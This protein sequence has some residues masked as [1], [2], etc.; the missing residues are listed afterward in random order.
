MAEDAEDKLTNNKVSPLSEAKLVWS[1]P[2]V[3]EVIKNGNM[4]VVKGGGHGDCFVRI[5]DA[6]TSVTL[7]NQVKMGGDGHFTLGCGPFTPGEHCLLVWLWN[8]KDDWWMQ[9]KLVRIDIGSLGSEPIL[10]KESLE[11]DAVL[12]VSNT[13]VSSERWGPGQTVTPVFYNWVQGNIMDQYQYFHLV[14]HPNANI[15]IINAATWKQLCP[16]SRTNSDGEAKLTLTEPLD[17][18][19]Y[20]LIAQ[21]WDWGDW[22]VPSVALRV[23]I[24]LKPR[25]TTR[26]TTLLESKI[27]GDGGVAGATITLV[28]GGETSVS[29]RAI[30][31]SDGSW[32]ANVSGLV[33][34]HNTL[35]CNQYFPDRKYLGNTFSEWSDRGDVT[36]TNPT[37]TYPLQNASINR[38]LPL[39]VTG[40]GAA[41]YSKVQISIKGGG[42]NFGNADADLYGNWQKTLDLSRSDVGDFTLAARHERL[43]DWSE[44][45]FRLFDEEVLI[46]I[47]QPRS[48][49]TIYPEVPIY[50]SHGRQ[51]YTVEVV[52]DLNYDFKIGEG[53][54]RS[55]GTWTLT[56]RANAM[57]PG[58]FSIVALLKFEGRLYGKSG[59]VAIKV[60]PPALT[61]VTVTDPN[62]PT[63]KFSGTGHTGATVVIT[64]ES[65]PGG[66]APQN[67][68][69]T[70]GTWET[71]ATNWPF[72]SYKLKVIQKVSDYA[73][74]WIESQPYT[75]AVN[76][77]LANTRDVIYTNGY[78]PTFSGKGYTG[79]TVHIFNQ[80]GNT[81]AAPEA[82]VSNSLWS[83]AAPAVWG[84]TFKRDVYI[85]QYLYGTQSPEW[86][87][88][89]VT[90]PPLAPVIEKV[91]EDGLSPKISGTCWPGAV[92]NLTYSGESGTPHSPV[93][94]D[95]RW[96]FQ[97]TLPFVPDTPYT[98]SVIQIA[99]EQTS[100]AATATFM[101]KVPML[102]PQ[103]T[104][105]DENSE[106]GRDMTVQGTSGMVG[107]TMQL[108]D[109]Q[110]GRTLGEP[111]V[112]GEE[113]EWSIDLTNLEFRRYNIDAQ[114]TL[115]GRES[116][117]S[118]VRTIEVVVLPPIITKPMENGDLPR[119]STL[120][121]WAMPGGRVDVWQEGAVEPLLTNI[122]VGN[123]GRWLAEVTLPVGAKTIRARQV[124]EGLTSKDSRKLT[125]NVVPASPTFETPA[126]GERIGR[127]V[128]ASGFGVPGDTVSVKLINAQ[129]T[130]L[131]QSPVLEDRTWSLTLELDEPGILVAV[132]SCDGFDSAD[133][134]ERSV[135]LGTYVP[136]I[137]SPAAGRWVTHPVEFNGQ[138]REG[139]GEV[140]SWFNPDQTWVADIP[141]S[142]DW[143][144]VATRELPTG[145]LWYR[146]RQTITDSV[147]DATYS[148]WVD[149]ER[150]EVE[151]APPTEP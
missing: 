27:S 96:S 65:G 75:F 23:V 8:G 45:T 130:E 123:N 50:G 19:V 144:G 71:T 149:S 143:Q 30:V 68:L 21:I 125:C 119:T 44:V 33:L 131:G 129:R 63:V 40:N 117:R 54:V 82:M 6:H 92:V 94:T 56:T 15:N 134:P 17:P 25:I 83:S 38:Y 60:R 90:I 136:T 113:G 28:K 105:P 39:N 110:F 55:D 72:G 109:A 31:R 57:P 59:P 118:D 135:L 98:V 52:Q 10:S 32:S 148:D 4:I 46:Y 95:G 120:E 103:I 16:N 1:R 146:F 104:R 53:L 13:Q 150:F 79:A 9:S 69:V 114:Q 29:G 70:A 3:T 5:V 48:G 34:G 78:T 20:D 107:A 93:V 22:F 11:N 124:F 61:Y 58:P 147:D 115:N 140:V 41:P 73:N 35:Y 89:W 102:K 67:V 76:R 85:K 122:P 137:E 24:L 142:R 37:F 116:L 88:L 127:R 112:L 86:T 101:V 100:P 97:R 18:G 47:T 64:I 84:P 138:G 121:G 74:G 66:T 108:R 42:H 36:V 128:V 12:E 49:D 7:S 77:V 87:V 14:A 51:G 139:V 62:E 133:S 99:A 126:Q 26:I 106:V 132:S 151:S 145:G 111:K 141:V 91:E 81:A 2:Y 80:G 43:T